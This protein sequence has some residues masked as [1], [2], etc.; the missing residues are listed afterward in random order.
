MLS[1]YKI[2]FINKGMKGELSHDIIRNHCNN[3]QFKINITRVCGNAYR[4]FPQQHSLKN[5]V[6]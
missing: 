5:V 6:R 4:I 3:D 2:P 1:I